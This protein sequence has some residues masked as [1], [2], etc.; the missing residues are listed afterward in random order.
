MN[1]RY[2]IIYCSICGKPFGADK[3][4]MKYCSD[5]CR[6]EGLLKQRERFLM[7]HPGY[8]TIY[9]RERRNRIK[10]ERDQK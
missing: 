8:N 7:K 1:P 4:N 6:R 2:R 5:S 10:Q 3:P 9:A